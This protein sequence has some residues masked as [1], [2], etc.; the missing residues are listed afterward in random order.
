MKTQDRPLDEDDLAIADLAGIS[1]WK[2]IAG[3]DNDQTGPAVVRAI[4]Q[5]VTSATD[6]K[7]WP[8]NQGEKIDDVL[9]SWGFTTKRGSTIVVFPG[10]AFADARNSGWSAY[11]IGPDDIPAAEAGLDQ[12]W[13]TMLKLAQK[14][15]GRP[16]YVGDDSS[17]TF[18][19]EW[20]PGA[21]ADR[22]HLAV[23]VRPGAQF[24][25]F[26][27]KPTQAPLTDAVGV[28]YAVYID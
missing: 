27:N 3:P 6:W 9:A 16:D 13:P 19:D 12:N 28:T 10:L 26:S 8:L 21:G 17:P 1:D 22:R 7:P 18:L 4:V 2:P 14:H 15:L 24:H 11:D 25:L 5:R 20:M 23:W